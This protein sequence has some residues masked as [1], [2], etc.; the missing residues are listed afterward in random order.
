MLAGRSLNLILDVFGRGHWQ[1]LE[2]LK[3]WFK[4]RASSKK[5]APKL[6]KHKLPR[7][8]SELVQIDHE[9][10]YRIESNGPGK[11]VLVRNDYVGE[12]TGNHDT[13]KI[14]DDSL[15]DSAEDSGLDPYNTGGFDRSKNWDRRFGK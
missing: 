5:S 8:D 9:H 12:D 11:N 1:M 14:L 7:P 10:V 15:A 4:V 13:L 2:K 6:K 3:S